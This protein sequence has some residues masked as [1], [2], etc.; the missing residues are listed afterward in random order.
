MI[1]ISAKRVRGRFRWLK[2]A[3]NIELSETRSQFETFSIVFNDCNCEGSLIRE[4]TSD[5][6]TNNYT[7]I[8]APLWLKCTSA[9]KF[10]RSKVALFLSSLYNYNSFGVKMHLTR[11][12]ANWLIGFCKSFSSRRNERERMKHKINKKSVCCSV[13]LVLTK[14]TNLYQQ[15]KLFLIFQTG[16]KAIQISHQQSSW[17]YLV[18]LSVSVSVSDSVC[19]LKCLQHYR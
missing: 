16:R 6:Q 7:C 14:Q 11:W 3:F 9:R 19:W 5:N 4:A 12:S 15:V 10:L 1:K 8:I 13:W 17:N 2:S 18:C